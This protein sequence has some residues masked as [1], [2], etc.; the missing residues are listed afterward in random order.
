MCF[1]LTGWLKKSLKMQRIETGWYMK[2][3]CFPGRPAHLNFDPT[4]KIWNFKLK[5]SYHEP[6]L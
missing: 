5:Y 1:V 6:A 3:A 4:A 2:T